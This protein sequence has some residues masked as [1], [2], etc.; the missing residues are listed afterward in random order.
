LGLDDYIKIVTKPMDLTT[1]KNNV[2]NTRYRNLPEAIEDIRLIWHNSTVYN[3]P[4]SLAYKR[5]KTMSSYFESLLSSLNIL[6]DDINR[7]PTVDEL[8]SLVAS[9][10]SLD[11]E[12]LIKIISLIDTKSSYAIIKLNE[13]NEIQLHLDLLKGGV[14][15]EILQHIADVK[16]KNR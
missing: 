15:Q 9:I 8:N 2:L 6:P 11:Q 1:V 13:L 5:A 4:A 16:N 3:S 10:Y 7:P 14:Y 12:D